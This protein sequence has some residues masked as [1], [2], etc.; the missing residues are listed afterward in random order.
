MKVILQKQLKNKGIK[1]DI[2]EVKDGFA[3]NYLIPNKIAC[4]CT[5]E[6]L[7]FNNKYLRK[8]AKLKL[9]QENSLNSLYQKLNLKEITFF[10]KAKKDTNEVYGSINV[11]QFLKKLNLELKTN[12]NKNM[13]LNFKKFDQFKQ[14]KIKIK[15]KSDLFAV[16]LVNL[17]KE[18]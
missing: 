2:I 18:N 17:K 5:K 11:S 10:L 15:I 6:N 9:E 3:L 7:N 12:V 14:Y 8:V 1:G 16:I 13:L 4:Y